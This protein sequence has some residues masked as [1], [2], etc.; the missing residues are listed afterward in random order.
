MAEATGR[1]LGSIR[2]LRWDDWDFKK[3]TLRWRGEADKKGRDA[4]IPVPESLITEV[5][6]FRVKMG[7]A[8]GG[9][10]FPSEKN[11][12]E[13]LDRHELRTWLELAEKHAKL[14]KL[15]GSLWHAYRRA[16]ATSRKHLPVGDVA[17]AGGWRD[18][19]TLLR[20]YTQADNDTILAV[21]SE[22]RK[23]MEKAVSR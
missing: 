19:T 6:V 9:L 8:F 18:V 13:P 7:G 17:A 16:W 5:K 21:M 15:E 3:S 14:P 1:R 11:R 2:Q 4:V 20:C 23:V 10:L 12:D 22:P